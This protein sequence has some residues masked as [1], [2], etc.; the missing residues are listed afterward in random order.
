MTIYRNTTRGCRTPSSKLA[1]DMPRNFDDI[2]WISRFALKDGEPVAGDENMMKQ[3][4]SDGFFQVALGLHEG[5]ARTIDLLKTAQ[6]ID[7]TM[8]YKSGRRALFTLKSDLPDDQAFAQ[9]LDAWERHVMTSTCCRCNDPRCPCV[10]AV[11]DGGY[12]VGT[13]RE[14]SAMKHITRLLLC[15]LPIALVGLLSTFVDL[16]TRSPP[17]ADGE[18]AASCRRWWAGNASA[19]A[20]DYNAEHLGASTQAEGHRD[21]VQARLSSLR[22]RRVIP[23]GPAQLLFRGAGQAA[24]RAQAAEPIGE[25]SPRGDAAFPAAS[26]ATA[27]ALVA[28][29]TAKPG[30]ILMSFGDYD[31]LRMTLGCG[32]RRGRHCHAGPGEDDKEFLLSETSACPAYEQW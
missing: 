4:S 26:I 8:V 24:R 25:C 16:R 23:R 2:E 12:G 7:I 3:A 11:S 17:G 6:W 10:R 15:A 1:I 29:R 20:R 30:K 19:F 22:S 27:A 31:Y 13:R 5:S 21:R 9:L 18:L 28:K 14:A 32:G